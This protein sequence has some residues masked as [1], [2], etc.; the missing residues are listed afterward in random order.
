MKLIDKLAWVLIQDKRLLLA[1]SKGKVLFYLPGGK[2]ETGETDI[3]ALSREIQEELS[4]HLNE[5]T[6]EFM[7]E[8][9]A[10]ADEKSVGTNVKISCYTANYIGTI[11][12]DSEIDE[13]K[14]LKYS[15]IDQVS[16]VTKVVMRQLKYQLELL[17]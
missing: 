7:G 6:M 17:D 15:D 14:W 5:S 16:E 2:R 9:L 11:S 1:R 13:I 8:Y 3:E 4:V 12:P 10:Q